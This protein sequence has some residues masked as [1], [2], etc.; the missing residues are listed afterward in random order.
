MI[1]KK[2]ILHLCEHFGGAEASLHGVARSFQW[3]IP[4]F[5]ETKFR[6]LL[7]S[8]KG[9]DKA[10][11]EMR[12][13]GLHPLTLGYHKFDFR[14][15]FALIRLLRRE[16]VDLIHA[17]GMGASM[18]A[19]LAEFYLKTPV[20]VHGRCN[21]GTVPVFQRPVE[22]ML[23]PRTK[24]ALAVSE[25]TR[26]FTIRKRYIPAE[27]VQVLYNGIVLDHI[28]HLSSGEIAQM[29]EDEFNVPTDRMVLGVVGRLESHKGHLDVLQA[30]RSLKDL[31][32]EL[33]IIGDGAY[34]APIEKAIRENQLTG[35]VRMLGFRRD[36]IRCI[37][38]LDIQ[39]FPSH[40]EGTPNT[41]YEA[42][43]VGN[44][45]VATTADG[46][47]EILVDGKTATLYAP[48]DTEKL[49]R[50]IRELVKNPELRKE[51]GLAARQRSLDFDGKKM[52]RAMEELYDRIL[53]VKC[54]T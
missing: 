14:N 49:G 38:C 26:Q 24:Y 20:I 1:E 5:D 45:I 47:G 2:T 48:G 28:V 44:P 15:L 31:P 32:V 35:K 51:R 36:I 11:R 13:S 37:Q 8:R 6:V 29:R 18:W 52:I 3:W 25:S 17:H 22:R 21:Y 40:Q 54:G 30:M 46:Q 7:C 50:G 53:S 10:Y 9:V 39:I 34:A 43:A 27:N 16:K 4:L 41:L 42:M 12:A 19:R 33:W 23:G